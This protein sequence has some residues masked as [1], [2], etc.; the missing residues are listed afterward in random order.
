[1]GFLKTTV[2]LKIEGA[3]KCKKEGKDEGER[4]KKIL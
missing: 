4:D 3:R 2:G 1:M